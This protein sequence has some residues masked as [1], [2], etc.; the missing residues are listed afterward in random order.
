MS[1]KRKDC[2]LSWCLKL[3]KNMFLVVI[4][5]F[6]QQSSRRLKLSVPAPSEP[7]LTLSMSVGISYLPHLGTRIR[8]SLDSFLGSLLC[9]TAWVGVGMLRAWWPRQRPC[10]GD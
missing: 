1:Q 10:V 9:L 5:P 2:W 6:F 7:L 8:V 4:W 3:E